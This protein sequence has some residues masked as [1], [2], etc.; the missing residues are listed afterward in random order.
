MMLKKILKCNLEFSSSSMVI[1]TG[2]T[3]TL[4]NEII[5]SKLIINPTPI[6]EQSCPVCFD[7]FTDVGFCY[8]KCGHK[9]CT[10]CFLKVSIASNECPLCKSELINKATFEKPSDENSSDNGSCIK[11]AFIGIGIVAGVI[12]LPFIIFIGVIFSPIII[13]RKCRK[14]ENETPE[15]PTNTIEELLVR[16]RAMNEDSVQLDV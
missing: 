8:T 7:D 1:F 11:C 15:I 14:Q 13:Y 4:W 2:D 5:K 12:C 16:I 10:D 6:D 3:L 9:L